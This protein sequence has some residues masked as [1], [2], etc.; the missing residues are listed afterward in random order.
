MLVA[1]RPSSAK[2]VDALVTDLA[3]ERAVAREAAIARLTIIGPRAVERLAALV[4]SDALPV[5]RRSALRALDAIG[6]PRGRTAIFDAI[7]DPD[8][9]VA[10]AAAG[11]ARRYLHGRY[12]SEALDRL[13]QAALDANRNGGVRAAALRAVCTL[14]EATVAPLLDRLRGD[15][16]P[17]VREAAVG[18][19]GLPAAARDP[20]ALLD[21][22]A[23]G[24]LPS[25]PAALREAIVRGGATAPLAALLR[26]VETVRS[27]E[28]A[29][30]PGPA[31]SAW[32]GARAAA[33]VALA[34]R[35]SRIALYDLRESLESADGPLPV[36][37]IAALSAIGNA[38]CVEAIAAAYTRTQDAW[39]RAH[40]AGAFRTIVKREGLTRRHA[41]MK[42]I[43]KRWP[44]V[45]R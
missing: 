6:D 13:T 32:T 30:D 45:L 35:G 16:D 24:E 11:A 43:E 40:L 14:D 25:D 12:G 2:E 36:E 17:Q 38:T 9:A 39:W 5:V 3:A 37:W 10:S 19:R 27:Q 18:G 8:A 15:S 41:V 33:H 28:A 42:R 21:A 22:A 1:I 23:A 20:A 7:A 29:A 44:A 26:V 31:R 4:G 34:M